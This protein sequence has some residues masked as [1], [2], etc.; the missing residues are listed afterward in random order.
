LFVP[1]ASPP[2]CP[3]IMSK[4]AKPF[5]PVAITANDLRSGIVVF[6]AGTGEW[7]K[8]ATRAEI[9][10]DPAKAEALLA[11]AKL[12]HDR[13]IVVEPVAVAFD[14]DSRLPVLL[15]ERIRAQGPTVAIPGA[16]SGKI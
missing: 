11:A 8:D 6:R 5:R 14:P 10:H 12:D 1:G 3:A 15:R 7:V 2:D 9:A 4:A 13:N 16:S